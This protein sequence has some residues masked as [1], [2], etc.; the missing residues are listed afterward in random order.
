ME[1]LLH[2][3][4]DGNSKWRPTVQPQKVEPEDSC[5]SPEDSSFDMSCDSI[6]EE[7][8][9]VNNISTR[10]LESTII[11]PTIFIQKTIRGRQALTVL[12]NLI[13]LH[14][15]KTRIIFLQIRGK[16]LRKIRLN[17]A[18]RKITQLFKHLIQQKKEFSAGLLEKYKDHCALF[19]QKHFRG[20]LVR[21]NFQEYLSCREA[22]IKGL[23]IGW[24]TRRVMKNSEVL[25]MKSRVLMDPSLKN[26]F[27]AKVESLIKDDWVIKLRSP[28]HR[29]ILYKNNTKNLR[30]HE[31]RL[32]IQS[33][34]DSIQ[35]E[36][37]FIKQVKFSLKH[38][39]SPKINEP[40]L[41]AEAKK[42]ILRVKNNPH[43]VDWATLQEKL[44]KLYYES[45]GMPSL[46]DCSHQSSLLFK[47]RPRMKKKEKRMEMKDWV[48]ED[49]EFACEEDISLQRPYNYL[50]NLSGIPAL[51]T[52]SKF[53]D[54][55]EV[56]SVYNSLKKDYNLLRNTKITNSN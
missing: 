8:A 5:P 1:N 44:D 33:L 30:V 45:E 15:F 13:K 48:L 14:V 27:I 3:L 7:N 29:R 24:K 54:N 10:G 53:F 23:I 18:A 50:N 41:K 55:L 17:I 37:E 31:K 11:H 22:R 38:H 4:P 34:D 6:N 26:E 21:K 46:D 20:F 39:E 51:C 52:N 49:F 56:N 47:H 42:S 2:S 25:I 16:T 43:E 40:N 19:I 36:K 9:Y 28:P 35:K 12:S 32:S